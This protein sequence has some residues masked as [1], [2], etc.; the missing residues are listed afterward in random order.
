M[1]YK[2]RKLKIKGVRAEWHLLKPLWV[3]IPLDLGSGKLKG[4]EPFY[5][6]YY[7]LKAPVNS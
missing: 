4:S 6:M 1:Y 3:T 2:L 7:K 5:Y